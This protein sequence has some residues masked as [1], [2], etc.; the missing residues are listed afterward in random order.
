MRYDGK[1][2]QVTGYIARNIVQADVRRIEQVGPLIDG[3]L[4]AGG[5]MVNSLRFFSS[6]ADEAR[7]LALA[8][9]VVKARSDAETMAKAAGGM[10]GPLIEMSTAGD[11]RPAVY[12]VMVS[13]RMAASESSA[14]TPIDPGEQIV[15][16]SIS[17]RWTFLP[18]AK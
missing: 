18:S 10:L 5:N 9:A 6:R 11:V 4:G 13:A 8:D 7:R 12:D 2:P 17:A 16:V 3:A 1:Q 15:T 14:P